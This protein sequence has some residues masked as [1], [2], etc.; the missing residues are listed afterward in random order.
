MF[1]INID[2]ILK[3]FYFRLTPKIPNDPK[4]KYNF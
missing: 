4:N 3:I 1:C 2:N